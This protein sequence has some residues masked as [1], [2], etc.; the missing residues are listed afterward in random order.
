[1]AV[2]TLGINHHNAPIDMRARFAFAVEQLPLAL[3]TLCNTLRQE[4]ELAMTETT[5]V[6]TCNRTEIYGTGSHGDLNKALEWLALQ[7]DVSTAQLNQYIYALHD[8]QASRHVFRVASGLDSM[9]LGEPQILGQLKDAVRVAQAAGTLGSTLHQ[10]FQRSFSVAKA[11]RSQTAIGAQSTSMAA[12]CVRLAGEVFEDFAD[13][14]VLFVGAGEMIQL[15]STHFAAKNPKSITIS[16]RSQARGERW[17]QHLKAQYMPLADL[18]ERLHEFDAVISCTASTLPLIGLGSVKRALKSRRHRPMLMVDL[19]VPRDIE[20]QV[21]HLDDVY[22]YTVDDLAQIVQEGKSS[23]QAAVADAEVI[24]D[25]GVQAFSTW[26]EQRQAV[27]Y[28]QNLQEQASEWQSQEIARA[29]RMLARG[30]STQAALQALAQGL[31]QKMLHNPIQALRS[32]E[33]SEREQAQQAVDQ[34]FFKNKKNRL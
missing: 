13:L 28:I 18:P 30:E 6:S 9:V 3:R 27:P 20:A 11:V 7:G 15:A 16:N 26:L 12:A 17:A 8:A 22:L 5:I 25:A 1:M 32:A 14:H 2:W 21:Q 34:L 4:P 24:V 31:T 10:M 33:A 29:Q 19:A 23:R